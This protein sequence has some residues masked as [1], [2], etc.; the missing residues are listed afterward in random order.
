MHPRNF[1]SHV[2]VRPPVS[3]TDR[4][5]ASQAYQCKITQSTGMA[6]YMQFKVLFGKEIA[7]PPE[8]VERRNNNKVVSFS[9]F[10]LMFALT[11]IKEKE[12]ERAIE[13]KGDEFRRKKNVKIQNRGEKMRNVSGQQGVNEGQ[14]KMKANINTGNKILG[15]KKYKYIRQFLH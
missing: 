4:P 2:T 13:N 3:P 1:G 5:S 8:P 10:F 11:W 6:S 15:K 9:T 12:L 14:W 7:W